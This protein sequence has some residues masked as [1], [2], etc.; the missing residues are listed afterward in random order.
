M[1]RGITA[2][3]C[4]VNKGLLSVKKMARAGNRIVFDDDGSYI[5]DKK[6]GEKMWLKEKDGMYM[7][8]LWVPTTTF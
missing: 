7:L 4:D 8:K 5:E 6:S 2:Q 3:I 1:T